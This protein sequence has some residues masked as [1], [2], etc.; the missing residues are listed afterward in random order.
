M[1]LNANLVGKN[2]ERASIVDAAALAGLEEARSRL[3]TTRALYP[4][5][6]FTTLETNAAV[7][8]ASNT[9]IPKVTRSTYVG[10]SG[11]TSGQYGVVGSIISL[12]RDSFGN[13]VVRRLEVNQE[14]FSKFAYFTNFETDTAV[15]HH[16]LRWRRPD[17]RAGALQRPDPD[18]HRA[19]AGGH[20]LRP[21]DHRQRRR[22]T[23]R[24]TRHF[25]KPPLARR[26]RVSR[27]RRWPTST[28]ST[29][30]R[31]SG[32]PGS[33]APPPATPARRAPGSSFLTIDLGP[34]IGAC[35]ASSGST[36][37][38]HDRSPIRRTSSPRACPLPSRPRAAISNSRRIA[39]TST[40]ADV[41][42]PAFNHDTTDR[43]RATARR[44]ATRMP[45]RSRRRDFV[46]GRKGEQLPLPRSA[47]TRS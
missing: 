44:S 36:R 32:T 2:T 38:G 47:A 41:S 37:P 13:K 8:D 34:A 6:G 3:N 1:T 35:R 9:A 17:P 33:P 39:A 16:R 28:S 7:K 20:L 4:N 29:A 19:H 26:G 18:Q 22:S 42:W 31:R 40:T 30:W 10:P 14:S 43:S 45:T 5:S 21:G 15:E 12:A 27:C 25:G 11:I 24:A 46:A 23:I